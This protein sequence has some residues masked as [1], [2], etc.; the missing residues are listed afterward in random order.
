M[1]AKEKEL[2]TALILVQYSTLNY[3]LLGII[4]I[5]I[6]LLILTEYSFKEKKNVTFK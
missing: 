6:F 2:Q 4:L 1:K 5:K 3:K